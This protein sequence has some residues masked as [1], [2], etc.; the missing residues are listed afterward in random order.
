MVAI[1]DQRKCKTELD[2]WRAQSPEHERAAM[3]AEADWQ[4][5]GRVDDAP[6]SR[7]D[8]IKFAIQLRL[9]RL[10]D[11][12]LEFSPA[13]GVAVVLVVIAY[14][15]FD[16]LFHAQP[17]PEAISVATETAPR[18]SSQSYRT[19]WGQQRSISLQDGSEVWLDWHSELTVTMT[20]S[21]R[22]IVLVKGKALFKV[23]SDPERPFSVSSERAV[24]TALGT[25]FVVQRLSNQAVEVEVLE[26]VV[27]VQTQD[28]PDV[29]RLG[30]TDVVRVTKGQLGAVKTRPLSE[31][32][33]WRTGVLVFEKRPLIEALET[34][35]PYTSYQIDARHI[36]DPNR[37]V[38]G[39][40]SLK[41]G[42]DALR[43]VMQ[44]YR[45]TGKVKG[46][47][48]LVLRSLAPI[49]HFN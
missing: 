43:V 6:L 17:R 9:A 30:A 48:T 27:G 25:Q 36:L 28:E 35:Q 42:D 24:A 5:L 10:T 33:A 13:L 8:T 38:S 15:S 2:A 20:A 44:N 37:L 21:Q 29:M 1:Y 18:V 3:Q 45:L 41:R 46:R 12:P 4:L 23:A 11:D 49:P 26:G 47:N 19:G 40:F 7:V 22:R 31:L 32:G 39:T 34:L 16:P 14:F